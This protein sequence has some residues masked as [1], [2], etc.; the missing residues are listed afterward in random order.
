M[1]LDNVQVGAL[2]NIVS[3]LNLVI[4][5]IGGA[6]L[7]AGVVLYL[8]TANLGTTV[9]DE[10]APSMLVLAAIGGTLVVAALVGLV[11]VCKKRSLLIAAFLGAITVAVLAQ[12]AIVVILFMLQS[13]FHYYLDDGMDHSMRY[14]GKLAE[15]ARFTEAWD[16]LHQ[17]M[18]CCGKFGWKDYTTY[19][20]SNWLSTTT[21]SLPDSL[22]LEE[23][24]RALDAEWE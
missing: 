21:D 3:I 2:G 8:E 7:A 16:F 9:N 22:R 24:L 23:L 13:S 15:N 11:A 10:V 4:A 17:T 19:N 18:E 1:S 20:A 12:F 5:L 6:M 14:Y